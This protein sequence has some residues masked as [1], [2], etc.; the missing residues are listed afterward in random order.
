MN[1]KRLILTIVVVFLG[2]WATNL[3]IH[4]VWLKADYAASMSLWRPE[5]EMNAHMAWLM[6]GQFL[7]AATF[8]L[9]WANGFPATTCLRGTLLYGI[10]MGIFSQA[11]TLIT[12]TVQPFPG[13]LAVKWFLSGVAQGALVG[14]L[15]YAVYRPK[16][17]EPAAKVGAT[18]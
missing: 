14:L 2:V 11:Q 8:V 7:F 4:L 10:C 3:L 15:A 5:A 18:Q 16:P 6:I 9:I 17:P 1:P 13:D 12:Y